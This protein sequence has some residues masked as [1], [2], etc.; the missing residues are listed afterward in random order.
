MSGVDTAPINLC[1]FWTSF[2]TFICVMV[3]LF[4]FCNHNRLSENWLSRRSR[5]WQLYFELTCK[6]VHGGVSS[7]FRWSREPH[8][9]DGSSSYLRKLIVLRMLAPL[10]LRSGTKDVVQRYICIIVIIIAGATP[11]ANAGFP[12]YV[13]SREMIVKSPGGYTME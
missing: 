10:L 12:M 9:L 8:L 1:C 6:L 3:Q 4:D 5:S 13:D 11:S 2:V 7:S